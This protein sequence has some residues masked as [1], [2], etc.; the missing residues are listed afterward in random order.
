MI[1][2]TCT[3]CQT[4]LTMDDAFAGGVCRCQHCGTIQTVP[5]QVRP[6]AASPKPGGPTP[7]GPKTL[8]STAAKV[9]GSGLDELGDIVASSGL[10]RGALRTA[11]PG[12][13]VPAPAP[14]RSLIPLLAAAAAIIV[15]LGV[16]VVYLALSRG[17]ADA[18]RPDPQAGVGGGTAP[19]AA[20]IKTPNFC[21]IKLEVP[22]VAYVLDRGDSSREYFGE[23]IQ[24][25]LRSIESLGPDRKFQVIF[26]TTSS[27]NDVAYPVGGMAYATSESVAGFRRAADEVIPA[28]STNA[29]SALERAMK[30]NPG[31]VVLV[32]GKGW[33]LDDGFVKMVDSAR[34]GRSIPVHTISL[35]KGNS[36][37]ALPAVAKSTGGEFK[38]AGRTELM[39]G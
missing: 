30:Q 31:A 8:Y 34:A 7:K 18:N 5:K 10:S 28:G 6:G 24:A 27:G 4:V 36:G 38:E 33:A 26:W 20:A 2:L 12:A 13:A 16:V 17:G 23:M 37:A 15:A 11:P 25:T 29:R 9:Q 14:V 3:H 35:G 1:Q 39:G 32:T 19:V 22:S 21:G